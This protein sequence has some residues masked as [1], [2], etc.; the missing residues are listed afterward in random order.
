MDFYRSAVAHRAE[1][2]DHQ[3]LAAA[4]AAQ[5]FYICATQLARPHQPEARLAVGTQYEHPR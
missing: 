4:Q 3:R 5:N 2:A 1:V